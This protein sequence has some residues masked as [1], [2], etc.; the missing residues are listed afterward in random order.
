MV[1][2]LRRQGD[3]LG[4]ASTLPS[5]LAYRRIAEQLAKAAPSSARERAISVYAELTQLAGWL[6]FN[7]G[8]HPAAERFYDDARS[9]A[10]DAR[11]VELVTYILCT[12]SH[13]ATERGK[14]RVGIDHAI[15][16]A[17][18]AE[19]TGSP[20]AR[21]YA[22]D[23][24]VRALIADGQ[25]TRS[26]V[27]LDREYAALRTIEQD[28]SPRKSWWYFYDESFYW[29]TSAQHALRF[30][31]P[32]QVL[33]AVERSLGLIDQGNLHN[34]SFKLL[35]RAEALI[36]QDHIGPACETLTDVVALTSVNTTRRIDQRLQTLRAGLDPWKRTKAVRELDLAIGS[37][38]A[39][40]VSGR[41]NITYSR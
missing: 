14:P 33:D 26:A 24:A 7:M 28:D 2:H 20:H 23:V 27:T 34:R 36:R 37:Y 25:E 10:H 8:D 29:G 22:A 17:A 39:T 11:D 5:A 9:A 3:V 19:Q 30:R 12:M 16:A 13:L 31:E 32:Q 21:A 4:A 41:T 6:C 18:W 35:F 15:A 1:P 40:P 38:R